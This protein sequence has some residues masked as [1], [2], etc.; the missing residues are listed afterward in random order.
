MCGEKYA[1]VLDDASADS[2]GERRA[3]QTVDPLL[4]DKW[5]PL[6]GGG[7]VRL[8]LRFVSDV[9]ASVP[10]GPLQRPPILW[11]VQRIRAHEPWGRRSC[12]GMV[13]ACT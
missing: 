3:V 6:E 8:A 1:E 2:A 5:Y 13:V 11:Y 7:R 4:I 9:D 10:L 12:C